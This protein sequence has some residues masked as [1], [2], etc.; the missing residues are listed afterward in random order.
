M[1]SSLSL[2]AK[3]VSAA[4]SIISLASPRRPRTHRTCDYTDNFVGLFSVLTNKSGN[5]S[6]KLHTSVWGGQT[7]A[8]GTQFVGPE[9]LES[10]LLDYLES[11]LRATAGWAPQLY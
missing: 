9:R 10:R 11:R 1:R 7:G 4:A 6:I 3:C 5:C 2:C 8:V